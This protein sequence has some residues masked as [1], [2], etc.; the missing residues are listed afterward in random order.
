MTFYV[1]PGLSTFDGIIGDDSLKE[2]GAVV[3]RKN[4]I[5]ST[6][7]RPSDIFFNRVQTADYDTLLTARSKI[8]RDL[9]G[10]IKKN[11]LERNRRV[12]KRRNS[13]RKYK[14]GDVVFVAIKKIKGKNKPLF[15]REVVEKDN[16]VTILTASGRRIHKAHIK[17]I[18]TNS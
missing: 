6:G 2:L 7:K 17:N 1:L 8:N 3:D 16:R 5:L 11:V 9:R 18:K 15:R 4:N 14:Q 10:L 13:P 12:N